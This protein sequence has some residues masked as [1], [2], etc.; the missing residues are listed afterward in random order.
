MYKQNAWHRKKK[1]HFNLMIVR[2]GNQ[3]IRFDCV[4]GR[5]KRIYESFEKQLKMPCIRK[6]GIRL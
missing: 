6:L 3:N 2:K 5:S 4:I 1:S